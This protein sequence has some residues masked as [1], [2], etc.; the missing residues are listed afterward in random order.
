MDFLM[1]PTPIK[2]DDPSTATFFIEKTNVHINRV[3]LGLTKLLM[4]DSQD[5][6]KLIPTWSFLGYQTSASRPAQE[7]LNIGGEVC[8]LTINA[9]DGTVIDRGLMY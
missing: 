7:G 4:K 9:I 3:E 8:Y 5:D 1:S 6:Y 2:S